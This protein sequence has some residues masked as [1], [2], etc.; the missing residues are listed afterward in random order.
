MKKPVLRWQFLV[1]LLATATAHAIDFKQAQVT[2]VINDVQIISA[3][4]QQQKAAALHD[5]F[6]MPDILR[7]GTASRA[8]LVARDETITRVGA[9]TIFSFDSANRTI[10]LKQG[11]LL[12]HAPHGKGGGAIQTGSA[13]ASVLGTTL[14]VTTTPNGGFKVIALEGRVEVKFPNGLK[15][16]LEPGQMTF[17]LP[18]AKQLA[19]VVIFRLDELVRNSLLVKGFPQPL[20]SLALIQ[21][22]INNQ[23]KLIRSGQLADTGLYAGD[24][25]SPS[26]VEVLDVNTITHGNNGPSQAGSPPPPPPPPPTSDLAEAETADATI[27]QPSLT[28]ASIPT[29]PNHVFTDLH[30]SLANN[31]YFANAKFNGFVARNIFV[32]TL[33]NAGTLTV[34]LAPYDTL[35][36]FDLVAVHDFSIEGSVTFSGMS[37]TAAL[38]LVAGSQFNLTA[39]IAVDA[40]VQNLL[41]ESAASLTLDDVSVNNATK[42]IMLQSGADV[43]LTGNATVDAAANLT[44]RALN[45]LSVTDSRLLANSALLTTLIGGIALDGAT[46]DVPGST[47]LIAPAISLNNSTIDSDYTTLS[48]TGG[49]AIALNNSTIEG[50]S[51]IVIS[52]PG[53][54]TVS[55]GSALITDPAAGS[56][57]LSSSYG[58]VDLTGTAISA[59]YLTVN[60]GDGIL[61]DGSGQT[62]AASGSGA[63]AK[64]TA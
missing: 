35:S 52:T 48:G 59:H 54:L 12:F 17:V 51:S 9:N 61:L 56:V 60:S 19:P 25:A 50:A 23:L 3:A 58:S 62:F 30:F 63:T 14:I 10:D 28:D 53:A 64:F 22:Q 45:N 46:L 43:S 38:A 7:T 34:N 40:D 31:S 44:V 24:D 29:P 6:S 33:A 21:N 47:I 2:Q 37:S 41:L 15:Q 26:Q 18:G 4:D 39:G 13:T 20:D 42:N 5:V 27:N 49:G 32:N 57:S 11:S 36:A 16:R 55:G 8:E 1:V